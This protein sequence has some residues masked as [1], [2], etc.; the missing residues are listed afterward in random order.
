MHTP[1]KF[2]ESR[3][4]L[5][6]SFIR[7]NPFATIVTAAP[8]GVDAEHVPLLLDASGDSNHLLQ[9][10]VA[11][12]NPVWQKL[13]DGA[14]VLVIFQGPNH[15]VSPSWYPSRKEHGKVVPTWNYMVVHVRGRLTWQALVAGASR[16]NDSCS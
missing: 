6:H 13:S 8:T 2:V 10:H 5:L 3:P 1:P 14:E 15:Y 11:R 4:A 12:A 9:G 7:E 16:Q